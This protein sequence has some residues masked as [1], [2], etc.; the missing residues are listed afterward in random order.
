MTLKSAECSC[1]DHRIINTF[2]YTEKAEVQTILKAC[3][4]EINIALSWLDEV[5]KTLTMCNKN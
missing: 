2:F 5:V 3:K 4:K 1:A